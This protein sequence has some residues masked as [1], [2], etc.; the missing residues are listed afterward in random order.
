MQ[1]PGNMLML[2]IGFMEK[3]SQGDGI[4]S[5]IV[6]NVWPGYHVKRHNGSCIIEICLSAFRKSGA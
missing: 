3:S 2:S 4:A 5:R 1:V 6:T